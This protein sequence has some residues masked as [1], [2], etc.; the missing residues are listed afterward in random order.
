MHSSDGEGAL[1]L[2]IDE[3]LSQVERVKRYCQSGISVQRLVHVG[4]LAPCAEASGAAVTMAELVPLLQPA[5]C[6]PELGVRQV[7]GQRAAAARVALCAGSRACCD[8]RAQR[9]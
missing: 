6:D 5:S 2:D 7:R 1:H 3:S 4:L 9:V 8:A